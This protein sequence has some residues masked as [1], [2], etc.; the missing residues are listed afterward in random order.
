[1]AVAT[2]FSDDV[3]RTFFTLRR[4]EMT[5]IEVHNNLVNRNIRLTEHLL[6]IFRSSSLLNLFDLQQLSNGSYLV[7]LSPKV[8]I[9]LF[10]IL[11]Q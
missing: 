3:L 10:A 4:T 5:L 7:R 6:A 9:N 1:M 2:D 8:R 11:F